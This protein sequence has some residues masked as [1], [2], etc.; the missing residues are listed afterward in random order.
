MKY[1]MTFSSV[2]ITFTALSLLFISALAAVIDS[3]V[4]NK[5]DGVLWTVPAKVFSRSL[6]IAEG[7][8]EEADTSKE[9]KSEKEEDKK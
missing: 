4:T 9:I 1:K 3:K 5:L 7:K 8:K 6:E 2:I